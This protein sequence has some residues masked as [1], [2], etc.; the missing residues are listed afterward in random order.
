M[1][2]GGGARVGHPLDTPLWGVRQVAVAGLP[3]AGQAAMSIWIACPA[4]GHVDE[5]DG[6]HQCERVDEQHRAHL[7]VEHLVSLTPS[8]SCKL[9]CLRAGGPIE[10]C[11]APSLLVSK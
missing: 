3:E 4:P 6:N 5:V 2:G 9:G 11:D 10:N 8:K 7:L 1:R